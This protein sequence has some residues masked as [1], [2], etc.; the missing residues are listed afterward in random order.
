MLSTALPAAAGTVGSMAQWFALPQPPFG[1]LPL[2]YT[3]L[4]LSLRSPSA[5]EI[6]S[7]RFQ[8]LL[9]YI[10]SI[11]FRNRNKESPVNL[12]LHKTLKG[13]NIK[14]FTVPEQSVIYRTIYARLNGSIRVRNRPFYYQLTYSSD[15]KFL[16][17]VFLIGILASLCVIR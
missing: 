17:S 6:A 4:Q 15:E 10:L 8:Y 11:L 3:E 14:L 9:M 12:I 2:Y 13:S 5:S 16:F 1:Q 7:F